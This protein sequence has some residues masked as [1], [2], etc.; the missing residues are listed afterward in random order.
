MFTQQCAFLRRNQCQTHWCLINLQIAE[1]T[2]NLNFAG[3]PRNN[4]MFMNLLYR[5]RYLLQI[6]GLLW[7]PPDFQFTVFHTIVKQSL[8]VG[9]YNGEKVSVA[10]SIALTAGLADILFSHFTIPQAG[11]ICY[12]CNTKSSRECA[13]NISCSIIIINRSHD[14]INIICRFSLSIH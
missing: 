8:P 12:R 1:N 2:T 7:F 11:T 4:E 9:K 14:V 10:I 3:M 13:M 5:K 6:C